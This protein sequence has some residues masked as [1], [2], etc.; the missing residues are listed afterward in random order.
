MENSVQ[1]SFSVTCSPQIFLIYKAGICLDSERV[2]FKQKEY[3]N[4]TVCE[5]QMHF[6]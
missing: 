3:R 6:I 4:R 1:I 2:G 5:C